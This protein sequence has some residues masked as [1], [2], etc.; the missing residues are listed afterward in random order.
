MIENNMNICG[1]DIVS[2][3]EHKGAGTKIITK[4]CNIDCDGTTKKRYYT[5]I[6]HERL[7]LCESCSI[8]INSINTSKKR[9]IVAI[10]G[11]E[12]FEFESAAEAGRQLNISRQNV[13][14]YLKKGQKHSSGYRF[15]FLD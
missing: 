9:P 2:Y 5:Y 10:R 4:C 15:E 11:F 13:Y 7:P 6:Q 3:E 12:R 1:F 8:I 14:N